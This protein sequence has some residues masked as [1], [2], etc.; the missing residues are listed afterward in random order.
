MKLKKGFVLREVCGEKVIVGEGIETV[1]FGKLISLNDTAAML[2]TKALEL[3]DFTIEQLTDTL[4]E[5]YEV[6]HEQA[7]N[8]V[9][10]LTNGWKEAGLVEE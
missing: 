10:K 2:W 9:I 3:G 4:T 1:N 6:N 8:D 7:L 5:V